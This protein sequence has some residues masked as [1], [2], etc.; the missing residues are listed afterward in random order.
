MPPPLSTTSAA[1]RGDALRKFFLPL[2]P[3]PSLRMGFDVQSAIGT[4]TFASSPPPSSPQARPGGGTSPCGR[5]LC[6]PQCPPATVCTGAVTAPCGAGSSMHLNGVLEE[7][8]ERGGVHDLT[9]RAGQQR[10]GQR[11]H[12]GSHAT[13]RGCRTLRLWLRRDTRA[14]P[15]KWRLLFP[16]AVVLFVLHFLSGSGPRLTPFGMVRVLGQSH[17]DA[18]PLTGWW[19]GRG[20]NEMCLSIP[21]HSAESQ[22]QPR[23]RPCWDPSGLPAAS[24]HW[25]SSVSVERSTVQLPPSAQS[26]GGLPKVHKRSTYARVVVAASSAMRRSPHRSQLPSTAGVYVK[27]LTR[28]CQRIQTHKQQSTDPT[29]TQVLGTVKVGRV[30]SLVVSF[31]E[32]VCLH[33]VVVFSPKTPYLVNSEERPQTA[34]VTLISYSEGWAKQG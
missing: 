10:H 34:T 7:E 25:R 1:T 15:R 28:I 23:N 18:L 32:D 33:N 9:C 30:N 8:L 2:L 24:P 27:G 19:C 29:N 26:G 14:L 12:W 16:Q 4:A 17:R 31:D 22:G 3:L 11:R 20:V 6:Q 21:Q 5:P 13:V